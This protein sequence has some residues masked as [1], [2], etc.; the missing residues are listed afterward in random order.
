[1]H[2]RQLLST[3]KAAWPDYCDTEVQMETSKNQWIDV[4]C[5]ISPTNPVW[6][7]Q[8]PVE[9]GKAENLKEGQCNVTTLS[10]SMHTGTHTDAPCHF[11]EGGE[12][13]QAMSHDLF[14]GT[15]K[16]VTIDPDS[17]HIT[18]HEIEK[19]EERHSRLGTGDRI[20]FK[21]RNSSE[22][23]P[24][25]TFKKDYAA[26]EPDAARLLVE[27]GVA[28][29]GVD[30][31]SV[32]PFENPAETH[33]VLLE[34]GVWI[35]EGLLLSEIEEGLYQYASLPLK[36]VGSD[37]GPTRTLLQKIDNLPSA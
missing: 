17:P 6:P 20:I 29:V 24:H 9:I 8:P 26:I 12:D 35:I 10:L 13:I 34:N 28:L 2:R 22:P 31:L 33:H 25:Q 36:I 7:G 37:A 19:Y 1:M 18:T 4:T 30:Y 32:A 5:P 16:V 23:W 27:R 14:F 11:L 15:T 3:Q 21:T